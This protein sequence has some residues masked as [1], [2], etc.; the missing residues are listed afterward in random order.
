MTNLLEQVYFL[1][2]G[3]VIPLGRPSSYTRQYSIQGMFTT[4]KSQR[5][6]YLPLIPYLQVIIQVKDP[7]TDLLVIFNHTTKQII[8]F[9]V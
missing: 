6:S 2:N 4:V 7:A 5:L 1:E 9:L 8:E 3:P